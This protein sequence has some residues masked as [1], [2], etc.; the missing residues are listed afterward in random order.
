MLFWL[1]SSL[2]SIECYVTALAY[3]DRLQQK[4]L[5]ASGWARTN[6]VEFEQKQGDVLC[7]LA[8][9]RTRNMPSKKHYIPVRICVQSR[10]W[11]LLTTNYELTFENARRF[12]WYSSGWAI[13]L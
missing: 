12:V 7:M 2:G 1:F 13:L 9:S 6:L 4:D 5:K 3:I 10:E 11:G 8:Q